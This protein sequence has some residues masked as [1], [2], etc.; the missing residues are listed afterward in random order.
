LQELATAETV[1]PRTRTHSEIMQYITP[2]NPSTPQLEFI[3][4]RL[5]QADAAELR[6][7]NKPAE[8]ERRAQQIETRNANRTRKVRP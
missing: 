3:L 4:R 8:A 2:K 7:R 1:Y 5:M 6:A